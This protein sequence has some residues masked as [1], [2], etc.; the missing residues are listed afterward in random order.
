MQGQRFHINMLSQVADLVKKFNSEEFT[1]SI[2]VLNNATIGQHVRH[3]VE[4]YVCLFEGSARGHVNY[5]DR[6]R[7]ILL[8]TVPDFVLEKIEE[9]QHILENE[10]LEKQIQFKHLIGDLLFEIP[11]SLGRELIY[12]SEHSIHHFALIKIG[13]A[14]AFPEKSLPLNFGV[15]DS[16]VRYSRKQ[17]QS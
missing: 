5:E 7:N 8:E 16:T 11:S 6:E 4:F 13:M 14:Q 15:A 12:L 9:Y 2:G 1:E 3:I 10:N 17:F